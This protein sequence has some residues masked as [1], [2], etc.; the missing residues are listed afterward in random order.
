[1]KC[2]VDEYKINP[3]PAGWYVYRKPNGAKRCYPDQGSNVRCVVF[4]YK[5]V[6]PLASEKLKVEI[7]SSTPERYFCCHWH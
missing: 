2:M 1:M 4:F 3:N 6:M 7:I 5:Y